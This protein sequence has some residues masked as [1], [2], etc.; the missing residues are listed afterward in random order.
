MF[1]IYSSHER[2]LQARL[3]FAQAHLNYT[4]ILTIFRG[5][6]CCSQ[7]PKIYQLASCMVHSFT[8]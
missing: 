6:E 2:R 8:N 7:T 5:Y 1:V 3:E 4:D